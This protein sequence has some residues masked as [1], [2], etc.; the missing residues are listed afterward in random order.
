MLEQKPAL[1]KDRYKIELANRARS[2]I[3][4]PEGVISNNKQPTDLA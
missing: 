3:K 2:E 1:G 4:D